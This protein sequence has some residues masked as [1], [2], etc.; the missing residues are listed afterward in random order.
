MVIGHNHKKG[1]AKNNSIKGT[2]ANN[3]QNNE[4]MRN[5]AID[6]DS[7]EEEK[8]KQ[9]DIYYYVNQKVKQVIEDKGK[10]VFEVKRFT[11]KLESRPLT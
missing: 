5:F 10:Y 3:N 6:G 8:G 7:F 1:S 9:E 4:S 11:D 2:A